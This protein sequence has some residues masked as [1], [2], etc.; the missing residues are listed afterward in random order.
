MLRNNQD[1]PIWYSSL[2]KWIEKNDG[3]VHSSLALKQDEKDPNYRS[4]VA[5]S[6][7][8]TGDVLVKVPQ[9]III[10]G[11]EFPDKYKVKIDENGE[12]VERCASSWLRCIAAL[13]SAYER[14]TQANYINSLPSSYDTL[15]SK[16]WTNDQ[17]KTFLSG[18]MVGS[19]VLKDRSSSSLKSRFTNAVLPYLKSNNIMID[20]ETDEIY[21]MFCLA[22]QCISTRGFHLNG[23]NST[24]NQPGP[25]LLP[26]IDLLNHSSEPS[27][28]CTTL[29]KIDN[30]FVM[31]AERN[32][33]TNEEIL[34]SY[35]SN[36]SA[37]L[38]QTFGFVDYSLIQRA[39]SGEL[40]KDHHSH[41]YNDITPAVLSKADIVAACSSVKMSELPKTLA[42]Q[43][44]SNPE[45]NDYDVWDLPSNT[46]L[47]IRNDAEIAKEFPDELLVDYNS[48][49]SDDIITL[50][51]CQFLPDEAYEELISI[52]DDG[53]R[54]ILKLSID[55]LQDYFLGSLVLKSLRV[56]IES[57]LNTYSTS[58]YSSTERLKTIL[59]NTS[60]TK[61]SEM[62]RL[63]EM[64]GLA[65]TIEEQSC[66]NSMMNQISSF[67][68]QL[69]LLA[70]ESNSKRIKI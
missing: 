36:T 18:T 26:F 41:D 1:E 19:M 11:D 48:P 16:S 68:A 67:E 28:R 61:V 62:E 29:H 3:I 69:N 25:Y 38:L 5:H 7:I 53:E 9:S 35:G 47:T 45:L 52:R 34:H 59:A 56:C 50:S 31:V 65:V 24:L 39:A 4:I 63:H 51:C 37:S 15:I 10:S 23:E 40:T 14:N 60:S 42:F 17:V 20:K 13:M 22:S 8:Q 43:L 33:K 49:L 6:D 64:Y 30:F 70:R 58:L 2:I 21:N 55:I 12:Q 66:L 54:S 27:K 57:K 46:T 44:E 32:I